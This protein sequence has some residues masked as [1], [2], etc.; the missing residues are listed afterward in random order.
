MYAWSLSLHTL[1]RHWFAFAQ[2]LKSKAFYAQFIER[3][4][5]VSLMKLHFSNWYTFRLI[6]HKNYTLKNIQICR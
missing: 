2:Q 6:N 4:K 1:L 5:D 3:T